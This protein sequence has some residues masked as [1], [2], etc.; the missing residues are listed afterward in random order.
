MAGL[1][2][3]DCRSPQHPPGASVAT[4]TRFTVVSR[5]LPHGSHVLRRHGMSRE[6][7]PCPGM[8]GWNAGRSRGLAGGN[9]LGDLAN[10]A[11]PRVPSRGFDS[12]CYGANRGSRVD[13]GNRNCS[14]RDSR[15]KPCGIRPRRSGAPRP[16]RNTDHRRN[17]RESEFPV[18]QARGGKFENTQCALF[19]RAAWEQGWLSARLGNLELLMIIIGLRGFRMLDAIERR[20][21]ISPYFTF[22]HPRNRSKNF[23]YSD[24]LG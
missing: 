5:L 24:S 17:W 18:I 22:A 3:E 11:P 1:D 21:S 14:L 16:S 9:F 19:L 6:P 4:P 12:S 8:T 13:A 20:Y 7:P 15:M 2:D 23:R 10:G